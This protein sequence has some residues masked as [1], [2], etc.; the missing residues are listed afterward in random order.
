MS[1]EPKNLWAKVKFYSETETPAEL[2]R[3]QADVLSRNTDGLLEG[4]LSAY[5]EHGVVFHTLYIVAPELDNYHFALVR[6]V[7]KFPLYPVYI[8]DYTLPNHPNPDGYPGVEVHLPG[9]NGNVIPRASGFVDDYAAFERVI[10]EILS[11]EQTA[12][13]ISS[14]ISQS[15]SLSVAS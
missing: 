3:S 7:S 11:S 13:I 12:N 2:L 15:K 4:K 9:V 5:A 10:A 6:I 1:N 8:Y 14:L